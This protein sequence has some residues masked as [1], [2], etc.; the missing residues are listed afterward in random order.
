[1]K[2]IPII[3]LALGLMM[4][5]TTSCEQQY[6]TYDGPDY[7]MFAE[8]E[9]YYLVL[10]DQ[11]YFGVKVSAT[12]PADTDRTFAVEVIDN[13]S[14][15]IEG[16]HY[17]LLSNTVTI[18]AGEL[19]TEVKVKGMYENLTPTDSLGFVLRLVV[20]EQKKWDLYENSTE[21]KVVMYK[22]CPYDVND[23]TGWAI[24]SSMLLR[25]YPGENAY[26]QRLVKTEVH[27]TKENTIIIREAFYDG[28][29]VTLTFKGDDPEFPLV[30][31]EA[32]QVLSDEASVL[33]WV[34]GDN[35]ILGTN[36]PYYD[37]Y[38]NSCQRF[39]VL[40]LQAYVE[41]LGEPVGTM[42]HF[43]NIIEWISDEEAESMRPDFQ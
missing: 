17:R 34:L 8:A 14:N 3:L 27:P 13:G 11:E 42:G 19:A 29:D 18:P 26:Y 41:D 33:G 10:E 5:A 32:D 22:S 12:Q 1:M 16:V 28:Y 4:A 31:M 37:S 9:Q 38:F 24:L 20:P 7:I 6:I 25:D 23:F 36:S 39:V 35:H 40:W 21:S 43:Y 2:R 30:E 15:A